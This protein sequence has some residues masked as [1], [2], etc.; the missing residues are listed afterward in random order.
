MSRRGLGRLG[1]GS[2]ISRRVAVL[3]RG[4]APGTV[5]GAEKDRCGVSVIL[6]CSE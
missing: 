6:T 3:R 4:G 5:A 2:N 1:I